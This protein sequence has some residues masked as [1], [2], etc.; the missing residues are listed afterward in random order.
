MESKRKASVA[1]GQDTAADSD[2]AAKR[3][4]LMEVSFESFSFPVDCCDA[5]ANDAIVRDALR[6]PCRRAKACTVLVER[7]QWTCRWAV[8]LL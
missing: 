1:S 7:V 6:Q 4:K 3:R 8:L 5:L 2:R